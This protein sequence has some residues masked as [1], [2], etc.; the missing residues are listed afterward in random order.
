[1][2]ERDD[3]TTGWLVCSSEPF[4][5]GPQRVVDLGV[6]VCFGAGDRGNRL[7]GFHLL[8]ERADTPV[9]CGGRVGL[10]ALALVE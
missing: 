4:V 8:F 6:P 7:P 3:L 1:M 10:L 5:L 2:D 9:G